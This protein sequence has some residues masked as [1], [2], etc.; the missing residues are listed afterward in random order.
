MQVS[1]TS[2]PKYYLQH[3]NVGRA[4]PCIT[5]SKVCKHLGNGVFHYND[6]L[7]CNVLT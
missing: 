5:E 4:V 1:H 3:Q 7:N 6:I 2:A